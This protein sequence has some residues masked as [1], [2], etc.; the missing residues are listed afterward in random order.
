MDHELGES[1]KGHSPL[2]E[3]PAS[4]HLMGDWS[5]AGG[6]FS[7]I[8]SGL[9]IGLTADYFLSTEPWLVVVGVVAGFAIGFWRMFA[10]SD[11][12]LEQVRNPRLDRIA[13]MQRIEEMRSRQEDEDDA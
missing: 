9:L 13:E 2:G 10:F 11:R 8:L 12:I 3:A 7:S 1:D 5:T 6:F 4:A